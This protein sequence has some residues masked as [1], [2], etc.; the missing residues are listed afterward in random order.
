MP[1]SDIDPHELR[2]RV[3]VVTGSNSGLGLETAKMLLQRGA[4]VVMACRNLDRAAAAADALRAQRPGAK[5]MV[6][7]LDLSD[8]RSVNRF[9]Q[10]LR[11]EYDRID[12]LCNNAG[13]MGLSRRETAQ[14]HEMHFGVN[15]LGHFAL[16]GHLFDLL[17]RSDAPRVVTVSSLTA[18]VG[19]LRFDDLGAHQSYDRWGA[20]AAS[21][22]ANLAFCFELDRRVR[23]ADLPLI[24]AAAHPGYAATSLLHGAPD[25]ETPA[26]VRA[27]IR[28]GDRLLAQSAQKGAACTVH[29]L[30]D[31]SVQGGDYI[32]PRGPLGLRGAPKR[33]LASANAL[34]PELGERL[35]EASL[36]RVG[37]VFPGL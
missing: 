36:Q 33:V 6:L 35:W 31:P 22:L 14:G 17:L 30:C 26:L 1:K 27:V 2:G 10:H 21:K 24:S 15:H 13:V 11:A 4:E 25:R 18:K 7:A 23:V 9:A 34:D 37:P 8:L 19:E 3:A 12:L 28:V 32:G 16:T 20:Y 5:L 29:A